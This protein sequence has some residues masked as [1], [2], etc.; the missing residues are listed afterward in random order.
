MI[1]K[2]NRCTLPDLKLSLTIGSIPMYR[3]EIGASECDTIYKM[4]ANNTSTRGM[5]LDV[6]TTS[7]QSYTVGQPIYVGYSFIC[8]YLDRRGTRQAHR[9]E[10]FHW[11][12]YFCPPF[13]PASFAF[14]LPGSNDPLE[15]LPPIEAIS[16]YTIL[17][18]A[19]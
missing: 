19:T 4:Y 3:Y 9:L 1:Y 5:K 7:K 6:E 16:F 11:G 2:T 15:A 18:K 13:L 10:I 8:H 12:I 17:L 14:S